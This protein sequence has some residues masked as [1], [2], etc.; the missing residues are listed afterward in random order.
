MR[1]V[2]D[3]LSLQLFIQRLEIQRL[4]PGQRS[5]NPEIELNPRSDRIDLSLIELYRLQ[6]GLHHMPGPCEYLEPWITVRMHI[7]SLGI[8]EFG[9]R[10]FNSCIALLSCL[11]D[12]RA[13]VLSLP[14]TVGPDEESAREAG[15]LGNVVSYGLLVLRE[16]LGKSRGKQCWRS[17]YPYSQ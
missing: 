8:A 7:R 12:F 9:A 14:V 15:L 3:W 11:T 4:K 6:R 2:A 16:W 13:D 5:S 1:T 17:R 10:H